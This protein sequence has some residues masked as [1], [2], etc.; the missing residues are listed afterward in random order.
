MAS[1][2]PQ[3][4]WWLPLI[5]MVG[6]QLH[7]PVW[8]ANWHIRKWIGFKRFRALQITISLVIV[9][10]IR[11][12]TARYSKLDD[13][14]IR[15]S[16]WTHFAVCVQY[17]KTRGFLSSGAIRIRLMFWNRVSH[18][19]GIRKYA[20]LDGQQAHI[21]VCT[22]LGLGL[23]VCTCVSLQ[24]GPVVWLITLPAELLSPFYYDK[25]LDAHKSWRDDFTLK[26]SAWLSGTDMLLYIT[27]LLSAQG[28]LK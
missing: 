24:L 22:S 13:L 12:S 26:S 19:P 16:V 5:L 9:Q 6:A 8:L 18:W 11:A 20:G 10:L 14:N 17:L 7:S 27:T 1:V 23:H 15:I 2:F 4:R 21:C 25:N 3:C 28:S